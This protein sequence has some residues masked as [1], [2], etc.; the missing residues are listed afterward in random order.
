MTADD[1]TKGQLASLMWR[2][3]SHISFPA[4]VAVGL[5]VRNRVKDGNWLPAINEVN[6][7]DKNED[8][9]DARDPKFQDVLTAVDGI[10]DGTRV[11]RWT[12]GGTQW[13]AGDA[14]ERTAVV[15]SLEIYK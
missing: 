11:D 4:M 1:Y 15:G 2:A 7:P 8:C 10:F 5:C 12:N 13:W 14:R 6:G 3:A 9:T